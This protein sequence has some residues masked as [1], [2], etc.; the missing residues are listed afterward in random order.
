MKYFLLVIFVAHGLAPAVSAEVRTEESL[1]AEKQPAKST[2]SSY[3]VRMAVD[4]SGAVSAVDPVEPLPGK[5]TLREFLQAGNFHMG[6][7]P[8]FGSTIMHMSILNV[9]KNNGLDAHITSLSGCSTGGQVA[10]VFAGGT[11]GYAKIFGQNLSKSDCAP[12]GCDKYQKFYLNYLSAPIMAE[13]E[14]ARTI[15]NQTELRNYGNNF[16]KPFMTE[17]TRKESYNSWAMAKF[18]LD[19][20]G[21]SRSFS[22]TRI[23]VVITGLHHAPDRKREVIMHEGD[24]HIAVVGTASPPGNTQRVPVHENY[25][26]ADGYFGDDHGIRG[27]DALHWEDKPER[28]LNII[29][30][31][32]LG[33]EGPMNFTLLKE[34]HHLKEAATVF[35]SI[36]QPMFYM[37]S[38]AMRDRGMK[39]FTN[40]DVMLA[41]HKGFGKAL[42]EP[43]DLADM[44]MTSKVTS[45]YHEIDTGKYLPSLV[46]WYA[47]GALEAFNSM[48]SNWREALGGDV[49]Y[50]EDYDSVE[51]KDQTHLLDE[52]DFKKAAARFKAS[53]EE[54]FF[55]DEYVPFKDTKMGKEVIAKDKAEQEAAEKAEKEAKKAKK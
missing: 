10:A 13:T 27:Y 24:L 6:M 12:S 40:R 48:F 21:V 4:P 55:G 18:W 34:H 28:V 25:E 2:P 14:A 26:V 43:M 52:P 3:P 8:I 11:S 33:Q 45:Y 17:P 51:A 42:D 29:L 7:A 16:F 23:P 39:H 30:V 1:V 19:T 9:L 50:V 41:C 53:T 38:L 49:L 20:M 37:S 47:Q 15:L 44:D 36:G 32:A 54:M 31:D 35:M 46:P 5:K 22:E